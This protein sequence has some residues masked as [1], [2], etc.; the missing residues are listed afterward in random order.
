MKIILLS[1][2]VGLMKRILASM[3]VGLMKKYM[4]SVERRSVII[5]YD[6]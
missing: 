5:D 6:I 1:M 4:F 3:E 2:D